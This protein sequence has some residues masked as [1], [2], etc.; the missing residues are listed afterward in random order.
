MCTVDTLQQMTRDVY[1]QIPPQ[2]HVK[3]EHTHTYNQ[4]YILIFPKFWDRTVHKYVMDVFPIL[5]L[6]RRL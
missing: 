2:T 5:L 3:N 6:N 1:H 4:K